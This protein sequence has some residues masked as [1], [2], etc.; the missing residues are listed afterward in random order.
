[1]EDPLLAA[2]AEEEAG[3][4]VQAYLLAPVYLSVKAYPSVEGWASLLESA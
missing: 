2:V 3:A 4:A 1:M